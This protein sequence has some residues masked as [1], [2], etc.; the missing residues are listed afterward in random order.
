MLTDFRVTDSQK[1]KGCI[2]KWYM[3]VRLDNLGFDGANIQQILDHKLQ[4][5]WK[6]PSI[7]RLSPS[8]WELVVYQISASEISRKLRDLFPSCYIELHS[9]PTAPSPADIRRLGSSQARSN[10]CQDFLVRAKK[11]KESAWPIARV[12]YTLRMKELAG[13]KEGYA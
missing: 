5:H 8:S 6:V 1:Y 13:I 2:A 9:D 4:D 12:Y 10:A 11:L 7:Y 3:F